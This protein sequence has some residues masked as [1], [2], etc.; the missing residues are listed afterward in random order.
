MA[1]RGW[2]ISGA[3]HE[4]LF[5]RPDGNAGTL[6]TRLVGDTLVFSRDDTLYRFESALGKDATIAIAETLR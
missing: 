2:W 6:P 1:S 3:V 4:L 5:Q